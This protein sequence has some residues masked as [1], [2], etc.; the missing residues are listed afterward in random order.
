MCFQRIYFAPDGKIDYFIYNFKLKNTD[1]KLLISEEKEQ[2]FKLLL[3]LFVSE[4]TFA[5][6]AKERFAQCSP[7]T[8]Q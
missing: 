6:K 4:Y 3:L 1:P 2:K 8:Y 7:T 5:A